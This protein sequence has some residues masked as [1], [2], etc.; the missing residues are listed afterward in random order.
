MVTKVKSR[1]VICVNTLK[2]YNSIKEACSDSSYINTS[3]SNISRCCAGEIPSAGKLL[4][5]GERLLWAY[6]NDFVYSYIPCIE[7]DKKNWLFCETT[8]QIYK[9]S[10]EA[11]EHLGI[12]P[13]RISMQLSGARPTAGFHPETNEPLKFKRYLDIQK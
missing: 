8:G 12:V 10:K 2:V 1:K 13:S 9:S 5:T 7:E 11:C 4:K 3:H 6:M